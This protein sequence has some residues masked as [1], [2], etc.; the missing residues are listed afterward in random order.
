[1]PKSFAALSSSAF[2]VGSSRNTSSPTLAVNMAS[3]IPGVGR[4]TVSERRS[5]MTQLIDY[6]IFINFFKG[7]WQRAKGKN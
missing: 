4:V 3:S 2:T 6:M 7:K 1:M 5:I